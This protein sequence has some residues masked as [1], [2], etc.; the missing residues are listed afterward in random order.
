MTAWGSI[1]FHAP[2]DE[3][4]SSTTFTYKLAVSAENAD[5]AEYDFW[6]VVTPTLVKIAVAC[7]ESSYEVDE[8]AADFDLYCSASGAGDDPEKYAWSWSPPDNLTDRDTATPTFAAPADVERETTYAYTA[9]VTAEG[10]RSGSVEVTVTVRDTDSADPSLT[11]TDSEVYEGAADFTLDCSVTNEPAGAT[12]AWTA[13]GSTSNTDDLSS[14]I[15]LKPTFDV[16]DD[17]DELNGAD[18]DYDYTVTL[19]AGGV[20]DVTE[21]VTVTIL[22]KPDIKG[23]SD[24]VNIS[25]TVE[26]G[27]LPIPILICMT[28][29]G[30]PEGSVYTS[31]WSTRD[32]TPS[33][34]LSLLS[35]EN[36]QP[37]FLVPDDVPSDTTYKYLLTI[38]ADIADD[39][40]ERYT[41]T[42]LDTDT[43][44]PVVTCNDS[45]VYEGAADFTL[46]CSVTNEPS[47]ATY[48]WTV[49][50]STSDTDDLSSTTILK[51]TF[52]VPD[53]IRGVGDDDYKETY[54]YTVTMSASGITD[55]A[56]DVKVTVLEKPDIYCALAHFGHQ[57]YEGSGD[58]PLRICPSGWQGAPVGSDYTFAWTARGSTPDMRRLSATN[59]ES[60]T[61]DV[62]DAVD[63]DETYEYTLTVSAENADDFTLDVTVTVL[64]KKA[65]D[66]ACATPSPVY[67][68]SEDITLDCTASGAPSGSDYVYAWTARGSTA[69]TVLLIAG[70]DGPT[71]TFDVPD[72][73]DATTTYEYLLTASAENAESGSA[74][75]T[76]TVLN[77]GA[78][79]VVCADP[80]SVYEGSEDFVLDCLAS[81]APVGTGYEYVWTGRGATSNTDLLIAGTDGPTPTFDVPDEVDETTTYEY[82]LTVSA[83]NA[84]SGSA[85]V[86]VTVLNHG[87]LSVVCADPPSVY[88]GSE[89]IMLDCTVSGAP[90]GSDYVYEWTARGGG[91]TSKLSS[92]TVR[93]PT[94]DVPEEVDADETYEYTLTVSAENAEDATANVTV[95]VLDKKPLTLICTPPPSPLYEGSEDFALDCSASG[96]PSGSDYVYEWTAR[97]ATSNTDELSSTT[98]AKPTFDV[99]EEVDGDETYEYTLTV[100]ADN[101]E[102]A[103]EDVTV[104]VLN[105]KALDVACA[106]PSPVYEGSEDFALDCAATGAPA[107]SD[108]TYVW[109]G[110]GTTSNTDLLVSGTDG[111]T[112]TFDVPE[113][114]D[115]D[116]TYEY[117]LT[118]SAENAIDAA[119][120]VTVKVLNLGSI[121]LVCAS[122]PLVYEGSEDFALDCS[123]LGDTGDTDY[124]YEW[125]ARGA[126]ANSDLLIAGTDGPT[127]TFAVPDQLDAT[128]TYEY[129]LMARAAN[130]ED[131]TAEVT[132]TVLNRG[133][134]A[135]ACAPPPLVYEGAE[136]FALDCT[137][138]GAPAGSEYAYVWTAR[139]ATSNTDLL[140]A[141]TDGPTPTFDVPE[142]VDRATTYEYLLTASA[143]NA[144]SGSA[145]VTVT[146]LN[147]GALSVVCVDP[148]SVYEGSAD[149]D[150]DCSASGAPAGSEYAYVWTA[151]GSTANTAL[152]IAG[153]DGPTPT[154]AVP[155][156]LD[157]ATTY[158]YLLTAS[159]ENAESGSAAVTVTVL[160]RGALSVVCASPASVYEGSEN[161]SF[162]CSASGAPAGSTYEYAWT[163]R[164]ATSNTDLLIAGTDGPTP[165]FDVPDALDR[166]TT[167]EYLLTASAENAESGSAAVTVTVLNRGALSVVCVDPPSVYEGSADFD[168]DCSASGAPA[169]SGYAYVWTARGST[170]NTA[171]LIAG[172]D[173]PT[174]TFAVPEELDRATTYEYLLTASAENAE[175]GSAAVTVT[176]LNRGAL[177]V[178]CMDPGSVYEGSADFDLDCSASGAPAGSEYAYVWTAQGNTANTDLLIA[179][180]DGPTP[181]FDV[182][183]ELDRATTYE[184][185]LTASAENA[186]SGSAAVTVTVL[187]RGALSVV[188]M[189]P[190]SVYEGSADF[191][192]DCS[193]S[194]D[195]GGADYTY[196]WTARGATT[197][198]DEL[199]ATNIPSP[200]FDVP[201]A[202][203]ATTTYEYLLTARAANVEDATAE[204]TVTVLNRGTLAVACAPPPL[205]YEGADDFAL[206]CTASGAPVGSD[207]E[208]A[209]T[210]RGS[211]SN[212]D[213]LIAGTDGPTPTFNVPDALDETTTYEYLLTASAENAESSSARVTVTVLNRGALSVVCVDPPSVYEGS[214]DFDLDCSA[215]GAPSGSAYEYAWTARGSTPNTDLLTSGTNGPTPTFAVPDEVAATTTYEYLLTASAE[216]MED[217]AAEVT[218]TVLNRSALSVVCADPGSVYEGSEDIT[219]DCTASGAP[220]GSAYEY[221]WTARESTAN[222][223][224]LSAVD[225]SS[226][227]FYVPDEVD[228]TTTYEYLLTVS[229]ENAEDG[230]AEVMVTVLNRG[231]A[232]S[233]VCMNPGSVY[234]GS[235][236]I[237]LDCT[238]SG[239][240]EGSEY[241]YVWTA[242]GDTENTLQLS[243]TDIPSPTFYVPD[244]VDVTTDYEYL[245]TA[246]AENAEDA[247]AEVVVTVL[248]RGPL[249]VVCTDP[250]SVYEGSEDFA[251]DCTAS[252]APPGP[253][254]TYVWTA[255]DSTAN[256]DL[257]SRVDISSPTFYVPDAVDTTTTYKYLLTASAENAEDASAEVMVTVLD[258]APLVLD[259]AIAGRVYIFTVGEVIEDVLLPEATGG[260]S[261]YTYT[262]EPVLPRGLRLKVDGDTT[263]TISGTPLEVSPRSEYTWQVTDANAETAQIAFFIE[264]VPAADTTSVPIAESSSELPEPSALGVTVSASSLR[265]GVRSAETQVSLDPMT[266]QISTRVLGLYHAG[267]MTLSPGGSEA[268][269]ENGEMDLSIE[270][271][272][273][274]VLRREGGIEDALIVLAPQWSLAESCEQLSSQAIGGLYT[275]VT[276]SEDAC[277]LLHFGGELDLTGAPSGRY[278]GSLDIILRSG[279]SEETYSV[280]V[281]VTVVPAQRVITIGPGGVHFSTSRKIPVG[282]TE[283]QNLSIYPDVAFLTEEKPNGVFELSNPSLIPLEISVSARFGYTEAT[284][285]GREVVVEDAS[286]SHLGDLSKVVDIHPGVL[287]LM[288]GEKGLVRYGMQEGALAAM[289][290]KGY[291]TFFDVVSEPRQYVRTDQMP[292]EVTGDR[293][294][295]VTMRVP[296]VY[297]PGEGASQLRATLLSIS[298]VG[299]MSATFLLETQDHPFAGEVVAYDGDG[300][301][302]GRRETLVYTRSRVR[303]P[304]DRMPE[305]G[306]VFLRFSPRGSGRVP[307][308]ASVEWYAPRRDIG[309]AEDKDRATTTA[310][311]VQKP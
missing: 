54:E 267:R 205:V 209:W 83:E 201:D 125:T 140:I 30:A 67:E 42:V 234:E 183:E 309:A 289:A 99:P 72:V 124:T 35:T 98:I 152:L 153:T 213:L 203:A 204:V 3:V 198:T 257:L 231:G 80:G 103:T 138:S 141:G 134:L 240:P 70:T 187:N 102:S 295:R 38:S 307:E 196:E 254:Y 217:G 110:R 82:L 5:D 1:V 188:C 26:E 238:A 252:G 137:A 206:D 276:L 172:T 184:Y 177:S 310:T 133:T 160:N 34:A 189:D 36:S 27:S 13:R 53:D 229:A 71:P 282:L 258:G 239:A 293:T 255:R 163:A 146:V 75:V 194:G 47:G 74:E 211:T 89:D 208:Y 128:T 127:P 191:A 230:A 21:D 195:T 66:V 122:P 169:G 49:R 147:R 108:Y 6:A 55:I 126:T 249:S 219:L 158:E 285:N 278:M 105:K 11:C 154:F 263:R 175:S 159:A 25:M 269:D 268:L 24:D 149:F 294:A 236:D 186:E 17:I 212:T 86:T 185:L 65:L 233:V 202:L 20:D 62:P 300:R 274:V 63:S 299:P 144:E 60:P 182:P 48:A 199:S 16:P 225:I 260:L 302:L 155:E 29:T 192:L 174:P 69:N 168:L 8:G 40:T 275:E 22:E 221:A 305:E 288:P 157:R 145:A 164:G 171:L 139:G 226:P 291:A 242:Q 251:F 51:P 18:K 266:D 170:A 151:R 78:L 215:S 179:G 222:T 176:V 12:Y 92:T 250:G 46:D 39:L 166:A 308:P 216:N 97:G 178:V 109:T 290:E 180:T 94:F 193:A 292:E 304:L 271:A 57:R 161:F 88:E 227:T 253:E 210:A 37:L 2:A 9:T 81:G 228:E 241:A 232:L 79:R 162:D 311:L 279:E 96:A 77:T 150:L 237:T 106:T 218:V 31:S 61:F 45:E 43:P 73:L 214:E 301:E 52:S 19:S 173:G 123:I 298:F 243:A 64:N 200:T 286:G 117:L 101:A 119:A 303:I 280:E 136:G 143:E 115:E 104:T 287:V 93:N 306:T 87:A 4:L 85:E 58:F 167:Y 68:G 130:V 33:S 131:A 148:P 91:D 41:I 245:L 247:S 100:S 129:L 246:S 165:T 56:E 23:C 118:V 135:V 59:I 259:D 220:S 113:E 14:S 197:N 10:V 256:T 262:L 277:R 142:V 116:E 44:A 284:E 273:P 132:V 95:R 7:E 121:A 235:E 112:P 283:E 272:S 224:Q 32:G 265:F 15:I 114:V 111:P 84:E 76:V 181:T 270:L 207:Y 156:E 50:G 107:G 223:D 296:G 281:E 261:P 28:R 297:A 244:A 190:G 90:S 264:V 120:E 248:N